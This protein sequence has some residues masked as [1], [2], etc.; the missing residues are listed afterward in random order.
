MKIFKQFFAELKDYI[1]EFLNGS[2]EEWLPFRNSEM[3][4]YELV[5]VTETVFQ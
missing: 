3:K 1:S 4:S 2:R 5:T